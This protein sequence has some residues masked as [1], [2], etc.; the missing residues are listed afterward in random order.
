MASAV[1]SAS[2]KNLRGLRK[3]LHSNTMKFGYYL[4][5]HTRN[6]KWGI[7]PVIGTASTLRFFAVTVVTHLL[8]TRWGEP[9]GS[10]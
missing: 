6:R 5:V 8:I 1:A 7:T 2:A 9:L 10:G 4:V 3:R